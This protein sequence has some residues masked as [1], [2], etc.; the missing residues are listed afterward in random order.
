MTL[1]IH[2][3]TQSQ[4]NLRDNDDAKYFV[5]GL[6]VGVIIG[7]VSTFIGNVMSHRWLQSHPNRND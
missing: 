1:K 2:D 6:G 5:L 4:F 3:S 7:T